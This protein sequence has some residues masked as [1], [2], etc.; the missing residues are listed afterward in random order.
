ME[1]VE[2]LTSFLQI[3]TQEGL[4]SRLL[5]RG[6]AWSIMRKNGVLPRGAPAFGEAIETDL[7]EYGFALLRAAMSL[8]EKTQSKADAA[9]YKR[10]FELAGKS[11]E[12]LVKNPNPE[13]REIGFYTTIAGA[14]YHIAG[15]SAIAFSL[16]NERKRHSLNTNP[17]EEALIFLILRDLNGLRKH[18]RR[19]IS[20]QDSEPM[21]NNAE[22]ESD[23]I[24]VN[25]ANTATCQGLATF[26]FALQTGNIQMLSNARDTLQVTLSL[27][28]NARFVSLWWIVRLILNLIDDLWQNSLHETLPRSPLN[29]D[30]EK[31]EGLRRLFIISLYSRKVS[32]VELWPSQIEAAQRAVDVD[33]DLVVALPTSAGKTRIAEIAAL[34]CLS[35]GKRVLIVTPLRALSA[36]T[37]RSFRR[38]FNPLGFSTSSLYGAGGYSATDEDVLRTS[39]I[40]I[41]TPEKVDFAL[42]SDSTIIDDV[43]LIILDEAHLIGP[44]EREIRYE[45][46]VQ[47]LLRRTDSES[48]RLVCLSAILPH[49]EE[50]NDLTAWIRNDASG[51]PI[52]SNWRPTRQRFGSL[53]WNGEAARLNYDLDEKGPFLARFLTQ[54]P[55]KGR[56]S[57]PYPRDNKDQTILAAWRFAEEG[58]RVFVFITQVNWVEGYAAGVL[59][60]HNRGYLAPIITDLSPISRVIEI[61][62][63]WLGEGH[64]VLEC[65]KIGVAIHHGSLPSAFLR[66]LELLLSQGILKIIIA[67]PTLSQGLNLN[68]AV[69]LMPTLYRNQKI[70]PPE[71]FANVVG[72]AGRAFVDAEGL[73]IHTIFERESWRFREWKKLTNGVRHRTLRSGLLQII[74]AVINKLVANGTFEKDNVFEYLSNTREAWIVPS[75]SI[76]ALDDSLID[77]SESTETL[78]ELSEKLD[79]IVIGLIEALEADQTELPKLLDEALRGSLWARQIARESEDLQIR[80][81]EILQARA[82]LIWSKTTAQGRKGHFAMG[83]GLEA[84]LAIDA[85]GDEVTELLS[86]A[87]MAAESGDEKILEISLCR[88]AERLLTLRP[89]VPNKSIPINWQEILTL[90]IS[91]AE[92]NTLSDE[93]LNFIEDAFVY[94][95][96]WAMEALRNRRTSYGLSP[97]SAQGKAAAAVETGVPNFR[98]AM[99]IRAGLPSRRTAINAVTQ[100]KAPF[101][102]FSSMRDWLLSAEIT[103][104]S[105]SKVWPTADS[106]GLWNRFRREVLGNMAEKWTR[107]MHSVSLQDEHNEVN[108]S[109]NS[110]LRAEYNET[111]GVLEILTSDFQKIGEI[112]QIIPNAAKSILS[113]RYSDANKTIEIERFGPQETFKSFFF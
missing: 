89:F 53:V 64:V 15:Y 74:L 58:K 6:T 76:D 44:S 28:E 17:A 19:H 81:R 63:E 18:V 25:I 39:N 5:D 111:A 62:K 78:L 92:I 54:I 68:C 33:D 31:Y 41:A 69:L 8:R 96:V 104:F 84:G 72:R 105:N 100:G 10:A 49:G 98:M 75:L 35:L 47:R 30:R 95:L 59:N 83:L 90:W 91:G 112:K 2:E 1:T 34:M 86:T 9:L 51:E 61:G 32:E 50:L 85:I 82:N 42:R 43:G 94:R 4:R 77:A 79:A 56:E 101:V 21:S 14:A 87:D 27:C 3:I 46:L 67:S 24:L 48:R 55:A 12:A 38:T 16:F 65:L 108:K 110:E 102:N 99:L 40:I 7:A 20:N 70:I 66:E 109:G 93:H 26:D 73:I 113:A 13:N 22:D 106:A 45:I 88:L 52:L 11:F 57:K 97:Y 36:Q 80:Q 37:E 23:L 103:E 71:E 107:E 60:L 29:G